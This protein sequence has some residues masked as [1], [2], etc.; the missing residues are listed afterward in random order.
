LRA[1]VLA[2]GRGSRMQELTSDSPKCLI[3]LAGELLLERQL[4]ALREAGIQ[5][6]GIVKGYLSEK[7]NVPGTFSFFNESWKETNMLVTL[8]QAQEWLETDS[9]II[10]YSDIVYP[11]E[12][13]QKLLHAVGDI[14]ITYDSLWLNL[15]EARFDDPLSDAESFR[16]DSDHTLLEIGSKVE[17][18]Q[19]IEGQYMGLLRFTPVGWKAIKDY[20]NEVPEKIQ[21]KM[22]MTSLLKGLLAAGI[23]IHT[24]PV[25]G[26]WCEVDHIGDL[27]LYERMIR[28]PE[29]AVA[30]THLKFLTT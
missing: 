17:D 9:S 28:D 19:N 13:V 5:E 11:S 30:R 21:K 8:M 12:T 2:A 23:K 1:V 24:V 4:R 20:L 10:S 7:I 16:V 29:S 22:D 14:V 18:I 25:H 6:I 27:D 26:K 15:W 3:P